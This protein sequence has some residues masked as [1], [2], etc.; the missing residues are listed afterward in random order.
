MNRL[1]AATSRL[2]DIAVAQS[3]GS[4]SFPESKP[5]RPGSTILA[6]STTTTGLNPTSVGTAAGVA[7]FGS[8]SGDMSPDSVP[9]SVAAFDERIV[10]G[11]LVVFLEQTAGLGQPRLVDQVCS[12]HSFPRSATTHAPIPFRRLTHFDC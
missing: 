3:G 6:P 9:A 12:I 5:A 7:K 8:V 1:E 11:K 4:I 10:N 2:E